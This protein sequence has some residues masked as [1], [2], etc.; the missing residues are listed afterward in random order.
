MG[1]ICEEGEMNEAVIITIICV[2]IMMDKYITNGG[3]IA[4]VICVQLLSVQ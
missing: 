4:A 3:L 1:H 2:M